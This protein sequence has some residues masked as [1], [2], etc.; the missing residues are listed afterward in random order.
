MGNILLQE[1]DL[2]LLNDLHNH[3]YLDIEYIRLKNYPHHVPKSVSNRLRKLVKEN[4][5]KYEQLPLAA[6]RSK[7]R[8]VGRPEHV[9]TLT[10]E[11]VELVRGLKGEVHWK[12]SW[13]QRPATF[14]YHSLMLARIE[15]AMTLFSQKEERL[16]LKEWI[17]EPRATFQYAK[18]KNRVIRPDG[19]AVI[20]LKN[21]LDK[22][23]GVFMEMERSYGS[24]DVLEKK[25]LRYND[26]MQREEKQKEYRMHAGMAYEVPIW[27]LVFV[28][29]NESREKELIRYL[30][31][32][33]SSEILVYITRFEDILKD[34]FGI[35]Y[36]NIRNPDKK[37]RL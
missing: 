8:R 15:C 37:V 27:R 20:G 2:N 33:N 7:D 12:A 25:I 24:K 29:G 32:V 1:G 18:G 13:S 30:N 34:P 22:N 9:F 17:N 16:E 6:I 35:I 28:A 23:I 19:I 31:D 21:E 36:R 5:I 26:F 11:G 3:M 10:K 4:Y 14:V